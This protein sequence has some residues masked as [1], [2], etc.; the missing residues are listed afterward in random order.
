MSHELGIVLRP[1]KQAT[2]AA[3]LMRRGEL[4]GLTTLNDYLEHLESPAGSGERG[5]FIET[6]TTNMTS[7][8]R[9]PHHFDLLADHLRQDRLRDTP[10]RLWSA[11]SAN[12]AEAWSMGLTALDTLPTIRSTAMR[13]LATDVDRAQVAMVARPS[14]PLG[15]IG[16]IPAHLHR[17]L[18]RD[19]AMFRPGAALRALVRPRCL[20]LMD[21]FPFKGPFQVI[22]C[23]NTL[24][25]FSP[26][27]KEGVLHRLIEVLDDGGLLCLGHSE[28]LMTV[29][30]ALKAIG[31]TAYRKR[32]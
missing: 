5:K 23:R 19:H 21:P 3:R 10:L 26:A 24:M 15:Q 22:F 11:G 27:T 1:H 4:L 25:Y 9:E 31:T 8:Y 18:E 2:V 17:H 7:F 20:N 6:V 28:A 13:L 32:G 16:Q 29:P 30:R 12:G 14:Y